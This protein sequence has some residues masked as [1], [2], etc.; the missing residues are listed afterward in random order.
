MIFHKK[1]YVLVALHLVLISIAKCEAKE[2][3]SHAA[4]NSYERARF[5]QLSVGERAEVYAEVLSA[6]GCTEQM[7]ASL[8]RLGAKIGFADR[9]IGFALVAVPREKLLDILDVAGIDYAFADDN[10]KGWYDWDPIGQIPQSQRNPDPVPQIAIPYPRVATTVSPDGPYFAANEIALGELWKRHPKADGRGVRVAV[11]DNGFDLLYPEL[12]T[13][14]DAAGKFVPKIVDISS[15]TSPDLDSSWVRLGDPIQIKG[16]TFEAAG[17][18][19]IA[20]ADGTYRFGVFMQNL[21]LGI[22]VDPHAKKLHLSVGVLWNETTNQVWVDTDGDGSFKNQRAL[23][24]Y[25]VTQ[26]IEWFGKKMNDEDN[27]IPFGVKIDLYQNAVYIRIGGNHGTLVGSALAGNTLTGGLFNGAAPGAQLLDSDYS[28]LTYLSA[29]LSM[30][31]RRDADVINRSGGVGRAT[32]SEDFQRHVVERAVSGYNK[33]IATVSQAAGTIGVFD[34]ASAEMLR[35]NRQVG[36]PYREVINSFV[37]FVPSGLVNTVLAPSANIM[38]QSRYMPMNLPSE[39]G[40]RRFMGRPGVPAPVG[41]DIG[42][43]NSPTIPVVSGVLADLISEAK[44]EHVR[45]N[46]L[47]LNNAIFTGTRLLEGFPVWQQGYGLIDADRSWRQLVEMAKADDPGNKEL[48]SFTV[49]RMQAGRSAEVQGF[50]ADLGRPG[51]KLE[52]DIWVTRQGGYSGGRKYT[53]SLRGNDGSYELLDHKAIMLRG[54]AVRIRFKTDGTSGYHVVF[55]ELRDVKAKVVMQDVPLSVKVPEVPHVIAPGVDKYESTIPPLRLEVRDFH[56]GDEVQAARYVMHIP[57]TGPDNIDLRIFPGSSYGTKTTPPGEPVDAAHHVGPMEELRSLVPNDHN[58]TTHYIEWEN[59]G[60]SEY[61]TQYDGPAPDV[62]I[63]GELT[64]AKYAVTI[65]RASKDTLT[66][67]NK[68]ADIDGRIELY[69]ATLKASQL[70]GTGLHGSGELERTLPAHLAQW[71]V[72]VTADPT[73][74]TPLDVYLLNCS[75]EK[76]GCSVAAQQE[77]S[78]SA[79]ALTV[80][81]PQTGNWRIVVRSRSQV[82]QAVRYEVHEALLTSS[83]IPVESTSTKHSSAE[84]WTVSLPKRQ[85]DAQ[86]AAFRIAGTPDVESEKNGLPIAMTP[87]DVAAP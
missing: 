71:R 39:D 27:R 68:L 20:P 41:Y 62:P 12:Q 46:A 22:D 9:T 61:A 37:Q 29:M 57:Y 78:G 6:T 66:V 80:D 48:T 11:S 81:N 67:T 30:F 10:D 87:L 26:D 43:N 28:P 54:K 38:G 4:L 32:E 64:I 13:A 56:L 53:L 25:G 82:P 40:I 76:R 33:P 35:R 49:S 34:Y 2:C 36:P 5:V 55:L 79:K 65:E 15:V 51:E 74:E 19:W 3:S 18:T 17:R 52:E 1:L 24:D 45:Y 47:R 85:N 60:R 58:S 63:H 72:R 73:F 8:S 23:G 7:L 59:R 16:G 42:S 21:S 77:I 75:D 44:R 86:Y 70:A 84:T 14:R 69:D 50:H 83:Q 31:A